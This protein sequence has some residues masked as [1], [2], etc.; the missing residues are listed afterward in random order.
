MV[1]QK[2]GREGERGVQP[3]EATIFFFDFFFLTTAVDRNQTS[4]K[5]KQNKSATVD[6][7]YD[8]SVN[9]YWKVWKYFFLK[10]AW[11]KRIT[12][13]EGLKCHP[14]DSRCRRYFFVLFFCCCFFVFFV[15]LF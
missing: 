2:E 6:R 3:C 10:P 12:E 7:I 13:G 8:V 9:I 1:E 15:F 11:D 5:S 4:Q 14:F